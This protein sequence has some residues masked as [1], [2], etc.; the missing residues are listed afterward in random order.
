MTKSTLPPRHRKILLDMLSL[1]T[2][3]FAEH[4]VIKH[5]ER[6]IAR[7]KNAVLTR[8]KVG[9]LLVHVKR[10]N[11]R[12]QRPVCI[13]A[14][15]DHPGFIAE[16]MIPAK[17]GTKSAA[18]KSRMSSRGR[19]SQSAGN[20]RQ[21]SAFWRGGVP[22]EYFIGAKVRFYV[23]GSWI[24]GTIRATTLTEHM[25]RE[26]VDR[27]YIDV[28]REIPPGAIG[29]WDLPDPKIRGS[30]VHARACDDIAGASAMLCAID[31]L[32]TSRRT[33]EAYFLFTRA[34]EVGFIG[35]IAAAKNRT[36]PKKCFVVAM[37]TSSERPN[38]KMGDGPILRVGDRASTFTPAVTAHC[39]R[40]ARTIERNDSRFI[41]Q[42]KLMDGG[43]CE[44]SAFCTLGYEAT[45]LCIALG[46]YHNVDADAKKIGMEYVDLNDFDNVVKWFIELACTS[47]A[48]TGRDEALE[49]QI[50]SLERTYR[51]LLSDTCETAR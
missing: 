37:E 34:E 2:A 46:N 35:A 6:F 30:R 3:P 24:K 50:K 26:R 49:K 45:G 23:E 47:I 15:L 20:K 12:V 32:C 31:A 25:G 7:R 8:D 27:A 19:A 22:P 10:G 33:C 40:I 41:Y 21:I 11:R 43:T 14:H 36:I 17:V 1:P 29:M 9:N 28:S 38:A 13:T 44:S 48:Y 18:N 4:Y 42:R 5:I 51:T 16:K 39:H